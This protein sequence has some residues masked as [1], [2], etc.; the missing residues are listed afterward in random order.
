MWFIVWMNRVI[1]FLNIR[2]YIDLFCILFHADFRKLTSQI[3]AE[4]TIIL[5]ICV[6]LRIKSAFIRVKNEEK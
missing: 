1:Y 3:F 6:Y 4:I 2:H 5:S